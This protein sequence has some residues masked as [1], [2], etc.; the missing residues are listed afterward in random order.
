MH[1]SFPAV[2]H[3]ALL[4]SSFIS[5]LSSLLNSLHACYLFI[6]HRYDFIFWKL[7]SHKDNV[8][9]FYLVDQKTHRK[10]SME[11]RSRYSSQ[12][13]PEEVSGNIS[14]FN[15]ILTSIST[16]YSTWYP[17]GKIG[18]TPHTQASDTCTFYF[19][20]CDRWWADLVLLNSWLIRNHPK[21]LWWS[22]VTHRCVITQPQRDPDRDLNSVADTWWDLEKET[23]LKSVLSGLWW[24]GL[25]FSARVFQKLLTEFPWVLVWFSCFSLSES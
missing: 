19:W 5:Y 10:N 20:Q 24:A 22:T 4:S 1:A 2:L 8:D 11:S 15:Y 23:T 18:L 13:T 9:V 12:L 17:G 7:L 25:P 3:F 21:S 6:L 14:G 16:R